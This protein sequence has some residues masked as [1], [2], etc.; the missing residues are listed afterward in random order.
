MKRKLFVFI[1]VA[2]VSSFGSVVTAQVEGFPCEDEPTDQNIAYG[3]VVTCAVSPTGDSDLFRFTGVTGE[4]VKIVMSRTSGH[5][6]CIEL[7]DPDD[8]S[9]GLACLVGNSNQITATLPQEGIY[10]IVASEVG[11]DYT[12]NYNLALERLAPTPSANAL[13]IE[14]AQTIGDLKISPVGD[15]DLF[16]F[17]GNAA[18]EVL[19]T[20]SR[21]SGHFPCIELFDPD[22]NSMGSACLVG[23]SNQITATLPQEGIYIIVASEIGDDYPLDYTIT[24][25]CQSSSCAD[26]IDRLVADFGLGRGLWEYDWEYDTYSWDKLTSWDPENIVGCREMLVG[27]FGAGR[28]IWRHLGSWTKLSSWDPEEM[29]AWNGKLAVDFGTSGLWT[30]DCVAGGWSK[31]SSWDSFH[32]AAWRHRLVADFGP[33]KGIWLYE[34]TSWAKLTSWDSE[35]MVGVTLIP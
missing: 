14:F 20:M 10:T 3:D 6:P 29:I 34:G 25:Q 12:L 17:S 30:Y 31:I 23:N 26:P 13:P 32:M 15:Q 4:I 35:D 22:G 28:G 21:T 11:D 8:N 19:I 5:Y 16:Y 1:L 2:L 18:D 24:L 33:G 27:D 7:F 9:M